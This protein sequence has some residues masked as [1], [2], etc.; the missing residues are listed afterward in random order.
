MWNDTHP[1][2]HPEE[3]TADELIEKSIELAKVVKEIDPNAEVFGPA[4]WGMLP[5]I[6]AGTSQN[7]TDAK[8][9][10]IKG[11]YDWYLDY[12]LESMAK[13]EKET[14]VRLL[15][16][17][18]V[19]YYAQ[20]CSTDD[21]KLQAPRSLYDETY[22][23]SCLPLLRKYFPPNQNPLINIIQEQIAIMNIIL[24]IATSGKTDFSYC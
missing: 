1:Y 16:V 20:D 3:C 12:Y 21:A 13:A 5:C 10:S 23:K 9:E 7:Y 6:Q 19:H 18:D 8:W 15:D 17:V 14:G 2:I 22:V 4:L 11:N 24:D